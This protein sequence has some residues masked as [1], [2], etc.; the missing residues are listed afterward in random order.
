M[1]INWKQR[2]L[3]LKLVYYGPPLSGKTTNLEQI[4]RRVPADRRSELVSVKTHED[5]TLFFDFMQIEVGEVN[6][7]QPKFKLYTVPGQSYYAATRKMVLRDVDGL[8]FV[9]D[10]SIQRLAANRQAINNMWQQLEEL[11]R[12]PQMMPF[13]LQC[14]KQDLADAVQ[15]RMLSRFLGVAT[16][17]VFAAAAMQGTGIIETLKGVISHVVGRL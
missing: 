6:G 5:R 8:V 2:E 12:S 7:L 11:G 15:P 13:V 3:H 16:A 10:S 17:D 14:N 1:F 4:H 9:A